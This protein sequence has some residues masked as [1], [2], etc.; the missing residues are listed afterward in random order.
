[1]TAEATNLSAAP[2][3][4][5]GPRNRPGRGQQIRGYLRR[6][7]SLGIGVAM[8][9]GLILFS[10]IGSLFVDER[11]A[12]PL[13]APPSQPPTAAHPFGSDSQ[14][15]DLFAVLVYGTWLTVRLGLVAGAIGVLIGG[16]LGF[17]SA[18]F[19][20]WTDRIINF[21]TDVLL[22][23]PALLIL[24]I[25]ASA[26][27]EGL[28]PTTM[29]LIIAALAWR[30]PARQIRAQVL[31]MR[32]AGYVNTA[33]ISGAGPFEIIFC[34]LVPNL[35]PFL[36]ASFV[37]AVSAAVLASI[38]LEAMGL[39]PK[40]APTLGMTIYYMMNFSA[41]LL[42]LWWWIVP[43]IAALVILFVGLYLINTGLDELSNPRLRR[44][45]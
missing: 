29:A 25:V 35:L 43:P 27:K 10:L 8:I 15:R 24:V 1:M 19:G 42:K 26:I 6:N 12:R 31:V 22:T 14:G 17:I 13:S 21:V 30:R 34:E 3:A 18:Y 39:G 41:F 37:T 11:M 40:N 16:A 5:A 9:A 2:M 45:A 20:G 44:R 28:T 32:G 23:V 38:G 36:V 4:A 33:R 7:P